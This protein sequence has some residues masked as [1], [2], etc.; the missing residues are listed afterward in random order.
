MLSASAAVAGLAIPIPASATKAS[1]PTVLIEQTFLK[2]LPGL[3]QDLAAFITKNWFVMD[4]EGVKQGIFTSYWLMEDIDE[5]N[6]W[7]LVMA[8][9]YPQVGGYE[10]T[11]T[12]AKFMAIRSAHKEIKINGRGLKDIGKIVRHHRLR[13]SGGNTSIT[14]IR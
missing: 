5:N 3:K 8:V 7:D 13:L 10:E 11:D 12:K 14:T 9:G 6:D 1:K 2:A 4:Q